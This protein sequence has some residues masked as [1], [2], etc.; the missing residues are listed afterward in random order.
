MKNKCKVKNDQTI[1]L[2]N[3]IAADG[4]A[5]WDTATKTGQSYI[6]ISH[7]HNDHFKESKVNNSME[8]PQ[9]IEPIM[10]EGT[11]DLLMGSKVL[12]LRHSSHKALKFGVEEPLI[13]KNEEVVKVTLKDSKH[14]L[15]SS[16]IQ[17]EEADGSR[18]GYSGDFG[19]GISDFI[20][21]DTLVLDA[22]NGTRNDLVNWTV[23]SAIQELSERVS[24]AVNGHNKVAIIGAPGLLQST[25]H[26]FSSFLDGVDVGTYEWDELHRVSRVQAFSQVY[27]DHGF[28]QPLINSHRNAENEGLE[29]I[30]NKFRFSKKQLI[31]AHNIKD[32]G[33]GGVI[34]PTSFDG[35]IFN[36]K[37]FYR[38]N[39]KPVVQRKDS[40]IYD[41][42]LTSHALGE[43]ILEYV[44][45]VNPK[46]V[47]T[48]S[49]RNEKC[50]ISLAKK[51]KD[52]LNIEA[53]PS[54]GLK[55]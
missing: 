2:G 16:Q 21:V 1:L 27:S 20:K 42:S 37:N 22:T 24:E 29:E 32:I 14:I 50:S 10:S 30:I 52:R 5:M 47:I 6:T 43:T 38:N 33:L 55:N 13:T 54:S 44:A 49:S 39:E 8:P 31:L 11:R 34:T 23:D 46:F 28:E 51:I 12:N 19:E 15:G 9:Y 35:I 7:I 17:V 25:I 18:Y 48:D 26:N 4:E 40:N 41:V 53:S 36:V 45:S 3:H